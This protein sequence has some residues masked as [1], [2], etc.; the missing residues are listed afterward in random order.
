MG[1]VEGRP[2]TFVPFGLPLRPFEPKLHLHA[3]KHMSRPSQ[4]DFIKVLHPM[5]ER[6][7]P[8]MEGPTCR[9]IH[10]FLD[11]SHLK[12]YHATVK[13]HVGATEG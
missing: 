3:E 1:P 4:L 6:N 9:D 7:I 13:E 5:V 10:N 11:Q 12:G 8:W 2:A